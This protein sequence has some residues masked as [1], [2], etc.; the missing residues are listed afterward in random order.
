MS[1]SFR[2]YESIG[3]VPLEDWDLLRRGRSDVFMD[4][5]FVTAVERSMSNA[6][7]YWCVL[8]YDG[9]GRPAASAC[10][11]LFP[12]DLAL[13]GQRTLRR[14]ADAVRR[15]FPAFLKLP[16][17]F[18]GLPVS[19]GQ[20]HLRLAPEADPRQA[21]AA[22]DEA[23]CRLARRHRA[24]LV[25]FKELAEEDRDRS[26]HL[27]ALGYVRGE[28]F[29]MNHFSAQSGSFAEFSASL[30]SHYRYKI[31]RSRRKL[32]RAG[33]RVEHLSAR[34][35]LDH[36]TDEVHGL[37]RSVVDRAEV[38]LEYLPRAFFAELARLFPEEIR[39][40]A[41]W[42]DGRIAGFAWGISGPM[43]HQNLFIGLD[44]RLNA[45]ADLYFNLMAEDLAGAIAGGARE[46]EVGQTA[47]AFKSRLGCCPRPRYVYVR[48]VGVIVDWLVRRAAGWFFPPPAPPPRRDLFRRPPD[49]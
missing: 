2:L 37:Y 24:L 49:Y 33:Y 1:Y 28:S 19:A 36:Y 16:V 12:L 45:E 43:R 23:L 17:L 47:D 22:V 27:L 40:T 14:A 30:R 48:G 11:S 31:R 5:R 9:D 39:F 44:Y 29:P 6:G 34:E 18:C 26:D 7:K 25:V 3:D 13:L 15:V 4:P 8:A 10:L 20:S 38:R 41:L 42:K 32:E 21:L 46:V 35:A